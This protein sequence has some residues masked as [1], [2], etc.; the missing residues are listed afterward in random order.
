MI[1]TCFVQFKFR[2]LIRACSL[3]DFYAVK[4][5]NKWKA[6]Q[7]PFRKLFNRHSFSGGSAVVGEFSHLKMSC[8]VQSFKLNDRTMHLY[9]IFIY[10]PACY[11]TWSKILILWLQENDLFLL[12]IEKAACGDKSSIF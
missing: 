5:T 6:S 7:P 12:L 3:G 11:S 8:I 4:P 1:L 9:K 2:R 10:F